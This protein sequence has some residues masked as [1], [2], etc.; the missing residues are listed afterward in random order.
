[1]KITLALIDDRFI[2][3][4]V[5][6]GWC[7]ILQPDHLLLSNNEIAADPWQCRVYSSSVPPEIRVSI[8]NTSE[9]AVYLHQPP[10]TTTA[11]ED[12]IL[13]TG[14]PQD[15]LFLHRYGVAL[16]EINVG[17]MH[18]A[19]GKLEVLPFVYLDRQDIAS[20]R[21][22]LAAGAKLSARQVPGAKE[23]VIDPEMLVKLEARL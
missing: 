19:P 4:Q 23:T 16:T 3:G 13:I 21:S 7:Q 20:M 22:L 1:M 11:T 5:T 10:A 2:H 12:V 14:N 17:G 15:M 8:Q 9:T 18:Y 6:A